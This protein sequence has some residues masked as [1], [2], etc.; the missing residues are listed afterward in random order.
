MPILDHIV[1]RVDSHVAIL[2]QVVDKKQHEGLVVQEVLKSLQTELIEVIV[3]A[4]N[5]DF[6]LGVVLEHFQHQF[7]VDQT[8]KIKNQLV[9]RYIEL[10]QLLFKHDFDIAL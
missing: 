1:A 10:C 2:L 4:H 8:A 5:L 9:G 6:H 7:G 3:Y